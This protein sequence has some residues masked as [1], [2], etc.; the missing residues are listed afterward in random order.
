MAKFEVDF[1]IQGIGE[2]TLPVTLLDEALVLING[3]ESKVFRFSILNIL[4]TPLSFSLSSVQAGNAATKVAI[5]FDSTSF[6]IA[7]GESA[8]VTAAIN[9]IEPLLEGDS[10]TVKVTGQS[11]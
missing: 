8:T 10:L 3:L 2:V 7:A 6:T 11:V 5:A 1:Q 9:P 4:S